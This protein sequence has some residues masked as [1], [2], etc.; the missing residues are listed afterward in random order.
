MENQGIQKKVQNTNSKK[1]KKITKS[2][3]KKL[4]TNKKKVLKEN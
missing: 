2:G 1:E 3:S 4:K